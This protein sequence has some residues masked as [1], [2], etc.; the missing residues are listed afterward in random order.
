MLRTNSTKTKSRDV[1]QTR[2]VRWVSLFG[3]QKDDDG[4]EDCAKVSGN[5]MDESKWRTQ[6][7]DGEVG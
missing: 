4:S 7:G 1:H 2:R 5:E 3:I 6:I